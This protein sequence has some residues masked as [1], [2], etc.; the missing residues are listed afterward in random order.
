MAYFSC[1]IDNFTFTVL[2]SWSPVEMGIEI[3]IE[4]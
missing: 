3:E 1:Y 4:M 2:L